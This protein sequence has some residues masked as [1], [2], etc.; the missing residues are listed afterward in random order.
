MRSASIG[1]I[2]AALRAGNL[3]WQA[4]LRTDTLVKA[5][6]PGPQLVSAVPLSRRLKARYPAVPIVWGGIIDNWV[7]IVYDGMARAP[8][9]AES[10]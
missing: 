3:Q 1:S 7:G 6:M 8:S 2:A 4:A 5:V 9:G 10:E